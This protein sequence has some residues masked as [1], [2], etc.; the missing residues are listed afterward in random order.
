[1]IWQLQQLHDLRDEMEQIKGQWNG[2]E[3]GKQENRANIATEVIQKTN[4]LETLL[5]EIN[6]L[7]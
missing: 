4:E 2:D 1:M 5:L 6:E 7:N 3:S